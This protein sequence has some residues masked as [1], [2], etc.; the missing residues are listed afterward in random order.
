[1]TPDIVTASYSDEE[2]TLIS[3]PTKGDSNSE[4]GSVFG[5]KYSLQVKNWLSL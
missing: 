1:M 5:S 4:G 3:S 2:N